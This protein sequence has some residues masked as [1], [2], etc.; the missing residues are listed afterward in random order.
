MSSNSFEYLSPS[1]DISKSTKA[2][3]AAHV[4]KEECVG[5]GLASGS[6]VRRRWEATDSA[7]DY[8][9]ESMNAV[10]VLS[11]NVLAQNYISR[12]IFPSTERRFLRSPYRRRLIVEEL[13]RLSA[14]HDVDVMCLQE[15]QVEEC[16][17]IL[18]ELPEFDGVSYKQR[19]SVGKR[20]K[21][22]GC[23][24]FW[25]TSK[26]NLVSDDGELGDDHV[27]FNDISED[28]TLVR[29]CGTRDQAVRNCVGALVR[30]QD[31]DTGTKVV[32]GSVHLFWDPCF[33]KLKLAQAGV[34]RRA[35]FSLAES[36]GTRNVILAG[37]WNS[38]PDSAVYSFMTDQRVVGSFPELSDC[39]IEV[40]D[41]VMRREECDHGLSSS[42]CHDVTK[43]DLESDWPLTTWTPKFRG[44]LDHIFF[45][46]DVG[47]GRINSVLGSL[48]LPSGT[49]FD[50]AQIPA[51]P[52]EAHPSDH[53]PLI[54]RFSLSSTEG[55]A[56]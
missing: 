9:L 32:I 14:A 41:A 44:A 42:V 4:S 56:V 3:S 46:A 15:L 49:E 24:V 52:C 50:R 40:L 27:E 13:R 47:N 6:E 26:F 35:A 48:S 34:Y 7:F 10:T 55:H 29:V 18:K 43:C 36:F 54:S 37:D 53:I 5:T 28:R 23:G 8:V 11:Y 2:H 45:C 16:A 21:L 25:R 51:L 12:K 22:D 33:P 30:L 20:E 19:T 1:V 17:R 39:N 31:R 38:V